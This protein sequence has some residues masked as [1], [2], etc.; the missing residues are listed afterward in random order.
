MEIFIN[1]HFFRYAIIKQKKIVITHNSMKALDKN[2]DILFLFL[3]IVTKFT[4][5]KEKQNVMEKK[6]KATREEKNTF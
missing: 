5:K 6:R 2:L 4:E 1:H 3:R